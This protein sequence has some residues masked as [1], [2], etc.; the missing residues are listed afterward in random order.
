MHNIHLQQLP[1]HQSQVKCVTEECIN[2][3]QEY[4][5]DCHDRLTSRGLLS[6]RFG[7]NILLAIY[8][9]NLANASKI[10]GI[11]AILITIEEK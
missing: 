10:P 5:S 2:L 9:N 6:H 1:L 4:I 3:V 8:E 11:C 7:Q